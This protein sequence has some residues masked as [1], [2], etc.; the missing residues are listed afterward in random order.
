[1]EKTYK[2]VPKM[3]QKGIL[4]HILHPD[5]FTNKLTWSDIIKTFKD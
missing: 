1:M 5:T 2:R 3:T 4:Y